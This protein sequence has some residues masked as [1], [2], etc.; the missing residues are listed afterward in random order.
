MKRKKDIL[1]CQIQNIFLSPN[2][3]KSISRISYVQ[4]DSRKE[5][6]RHKLEG[7]AL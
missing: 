3:E 6:L 5:L 1:R 2:G 7:H 4:F